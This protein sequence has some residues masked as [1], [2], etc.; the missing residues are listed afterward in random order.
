M[1]QYSVLYPV[2]VMVLLS[3]VVG[4][5]LV[6]LRF[7]A[8]KQ[9][10]LHA[11]YFLM[12]RGG[13]A[14]AYMIQ[15]EQQYANLYE[16]PMLFYVVVV[17]I[18]VLGLSNGFSVVLA[19]AYT[20]SRILHAWEHMGKNRLATRRRIFLTSIMLV[21]TMWIYAFIAIVVN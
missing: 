1:P 18:Y 16:T 13:K 12:N 6:Q 20:L 10:G 14:P 7:R 8:V 3:V 19:W 2:F 9:D 11:G 17:L 5:R 15:A 4:L 21:A